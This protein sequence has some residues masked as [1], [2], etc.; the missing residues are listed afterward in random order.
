MAPQPITSTVRPNSVVP[1]GSP[2]R[3]CRM[4]QR[5]GGGGGGGGQGT[6][7]GPAGKA[8]RTR[9]APVCHGVVA[10]QH[11][12]HQVNGVLGAAEGIARLPR[13]HVSHPD[14]ERGG[15]RD[16][17]PLHAHSKLADE[18]EAVRALQLLCAQPSHERHRHVGVAQRDG[19]LAWRRALHHLHHQRA[20]W[21]RRRIVSSWRA[22][23]TP[24]PA[25]AV[26]AVAAAA[27]GAA[28]TSGAHSP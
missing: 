15:E 9:P 5:E 18:L 7:S 12:Q 24:S 26:Q 6:C 14:A 2:S 23:D 19:H 1:R 27:R 25:R 10:A 17:Y 13:R 20:V 11:R 21:R 16:A 3:C 22:L 8:G 4:L 28:A